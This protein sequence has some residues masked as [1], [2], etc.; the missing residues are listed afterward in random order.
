M[1]TV[2]PP[3]G[4]AG[5]PLLLATFGAPALIACAQWEPETIA[6]DRAVADIDEMRAMLAAN[7]D[8]VTMSTV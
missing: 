1:I 4:A 8:C 3:A 6:R 2:L 5:P 7:S